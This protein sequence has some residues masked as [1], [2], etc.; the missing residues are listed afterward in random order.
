[1]D[2][3]EAT[4]SSPDV[5]LPTIRQVYYAFVGSVREVIE[6]NTDSTVVARLG[7][8]LREFSVIVNEVRISNSRS[9]LSSHILASIS[10]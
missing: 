8:R 5:L 3:Q 7:D 2:Q 10:A 9:L 1:M 6:G 4:N